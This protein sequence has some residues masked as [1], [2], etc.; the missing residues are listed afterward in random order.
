MNQT[1]QQR[2]QAE[3][4]ATKGRIQERVTARVVSA[5][6]VQHMWR[7][8]YDEVLVPRKITTDDPLT[9]A[10]VK[11]FRESFYAGASSMLELMMRASPDD[12]SEDDGAAMLQRLYEELQTYAKGLAVS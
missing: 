12:I 7:T 6:S 5:V 8:Y 9:A 10:G 3:R 1:R 11:Y 4:D 2:R